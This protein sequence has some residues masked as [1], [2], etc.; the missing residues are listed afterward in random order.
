MDFSVY[1]SGAQLGGK[2]KHS[3]LFCVSGTT[4]K[5]MFYNLIASTISSF[6]QF[7]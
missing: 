7:S 1:P 3:S 2:E 4:E 5:K 6:E